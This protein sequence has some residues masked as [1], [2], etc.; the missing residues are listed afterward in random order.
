M[1]YFFVSNAHALGGQSGEAA[2]NPLLNMLPFILIVTA[3]EMWLERSGLP[4]R[5]VSAG[6]VLSGVI[7]LY[8]SHYSR[9]GTSA[10]VRDI[11]LMMIAPVWLLS[12]L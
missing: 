7:G 1:F 5:Q 8:L 12:R 10:V 4:T 3:I 6:L 2:G 11:Q 9:G